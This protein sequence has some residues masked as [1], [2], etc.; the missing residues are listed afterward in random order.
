MSRFTEHFDI[1]SNDLIYT[2]ALSSPSKASFFSMSSNES[3]SSPRQ[4]YQTIDPIFT[5]SFNS[6]DSTPP[7]S[8]TSSYEE[9]S[10]GNKLKRFLTT[11]SK[12]KRSMSNH[13]Q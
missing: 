7:S 12:K 8:P 11:I 1:E 6:F 5:R 9:K 3:T 10:S 13:S 2:Q 4:Q